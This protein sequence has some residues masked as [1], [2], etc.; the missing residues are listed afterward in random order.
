[1]GLSLFSSKVVYFQSVGRIILSLSSCFCFCVLAVTSEQSHVTISTHVNL[2]PH[3]L[4]QPL[5]QQMVAGRIEIAK[6]MSAVPNTTTHNPSHPHPF[7]LYTLCDWL[8]IP[9]FADEW[10]GIV[11]IHAKS[12]RRKVMKEQII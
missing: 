4:F 8:L 7:S 1:M 10:R 9:R 12:E 5:Q 2:Q 6:R 3:P 11:S